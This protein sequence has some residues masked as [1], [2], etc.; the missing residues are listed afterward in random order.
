MVRVSVRLGL[1][2]PRG[3]EKKVRVRSLEKK[4][5]VSLE[6][7]VRIR[8]RARVRVRVAAHCVALI[9]PPQGSGASCASASYTSLLL[10]HCTRE[11]HSGRNLIRT[12]D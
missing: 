5:R 9:Q 4:V 10:V 2:L 6:E 7:Q 12:T 3:L 11:H 8:D 1:G